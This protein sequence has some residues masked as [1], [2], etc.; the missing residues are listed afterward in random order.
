MSTAACPSASCS[1]VSAPPPLLLLLHLPAGWPARKPARMPACLSACPSACVLHRLCPPALPPRRLLPLHPAPPS[2]RCC[3]AGG[4]EFCGR[5]LG[6]LLHG[7][8]LWFRG[9]A[10]STLLEVV[11][12]GFRV[13]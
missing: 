5:R 10:E 4:V 7:G 1:R 11:E 6:A 9:D 13:R 2:P 3:L 8:D 12:T